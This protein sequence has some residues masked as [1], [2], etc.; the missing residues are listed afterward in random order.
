MSKV[1][2]KQVSKKKKKKVRPRFEGWKFIR[3]AKKEKKKR[4]VALRII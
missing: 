4:R 2:I 3:E 1:W